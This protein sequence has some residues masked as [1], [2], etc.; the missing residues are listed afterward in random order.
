MNKR[1]NKKDK[2]ELYN[3][4]CEDDFFVATGVCRGN[5]NT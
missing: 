1:A 3:Q 4:L 2:C 5:Y